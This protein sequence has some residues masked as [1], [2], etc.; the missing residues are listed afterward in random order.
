MWF[1]S[2]R[3]SL[4][5]GQCGLLRLLSQIHNAD[6]VFLLGKPE[7]WVDWLR[8]FAVK[9]VNQSHGIG[10]HA[11]EGEHPSREVDVDAQP[12]ERAGF[13]RGL[14]VTM[15]SRELLPIPVQAPGEVVSWNTAVALLPFPVDAFAGQANVGAYPRDLYLKIVPVQVQ[16]LLGQ[17]LPPVQEPAGEVWVRMLPGCSVGDFAVVLLQ[18]EIPMCR[19]RVKR[20][21]TGIWGDIGVRKNSSEIQQ[22]TSNLAF[23]QSMRMYPSFCSAYSPKLLC[24][25]EGKFLPHS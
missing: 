3:S 15:P 19:I 10:L 5:W 4:H 13:E 9:P 17:H 6:S 18:P 8:K 14:G 7:G 2:L 21:V 22:S 25:L 23:L 24:L 16:A 20:D 1:Q 11:I 12:P